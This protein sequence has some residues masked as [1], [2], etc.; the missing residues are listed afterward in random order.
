MILKFSTFFH[1][2]PSMQKSL[3]AETGL[4]FSL[5]RIFFLALQHALQFSWASVALLMTHDTRYAFDG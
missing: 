5:L 1:Y 2:L 3:I 4:T